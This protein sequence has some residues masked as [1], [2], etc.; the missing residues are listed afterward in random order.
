MILRFVSGV[1]NF[2]G[3][4]TVYYILKQLPFV[5]D[6]FEQRKFFFI[7]Y[8]VSTAFLFQPCGRMTF[9]RVLI[10][11]IIETGEFIAYLCFS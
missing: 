4:L 8:A 7:L 1:L 11:L 6:K 3:Q 9:E 2:S 10:G 5:P